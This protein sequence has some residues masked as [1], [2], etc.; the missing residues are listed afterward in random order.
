MKEFAVLAVIIGI[1]LA[2]CF[3]LA[4][5][6]RLRLFSDTDDIRVTVDERRIMIKYVVDSYVLA[7][8]RRRK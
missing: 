4:R 7:R 5:R 8:L 2:L 1:M 6:N 3:D